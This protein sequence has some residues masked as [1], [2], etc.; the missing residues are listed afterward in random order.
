MLKSWQFSLG[1]LQEVRFVDLDDKAIAALQDELAAQL[2]ASSPGLHV[3][4]AC[5]LARSLQQQQPDLTQA[6]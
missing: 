1:A 5:K 4:V 3:S 6:C 2:Q